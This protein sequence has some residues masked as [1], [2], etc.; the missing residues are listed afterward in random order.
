MNEHLRHAIR[1]AMEARSRGNR[2]FGALIVDGSGAVIGEAEADSMTTGDC[3]G[4]AETNVL[5]GVTPRCPR[6]QMAK[7]TLYT[8]AE[9]CVM[10]AGAIF[11]SNIRRVVYGIDATTLRG[12]RGE[13]AG[14]MDLRMSCRDVFRASPH[15]IE[16]IG[17][18]L[19][20]EA[21][22]PHEGYWQ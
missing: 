9:P 6:E 18:L 3:T 13:V 15:A 21:R 4:H 11:W 14:Q 10:C 7:C 8:S 19:E 22:V 17:P 2:P 1:L 20:E 5:R 12:Y 16:V